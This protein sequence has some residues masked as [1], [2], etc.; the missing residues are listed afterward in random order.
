MFQIPSPLRLLP[1]TE[2]SSLPLCSRSFLV[3]Y[4]KYS[5][6]YMSVLFLNLSLLPNIILGW[7]KKKKLFFLKILEGFPGGSGVNNLPAKAGEA[8]LI[9]GSGRSPREG[10]GNPL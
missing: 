5:R 6:V 10:N 1:N 4:F 7:Q 3:I 2:H 8:S 9:P